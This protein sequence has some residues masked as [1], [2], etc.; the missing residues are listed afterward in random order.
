MTVRRTSSR[1]GAMLL[2]VI[3]SLGLLTGQAHAETVFDDSF[4]GNPADR[5]GGIPWGDGSNGFDIGRG[6][7]RTGANNGWLLAEN[8]GSALARG[9]NFP[10][11]EAQCAAQIYV[12]PSTDDT[13]MVLEVWGLDPNSSGVYEWR[14]RN[15]SEHRLNAGGY[16]AVGFGVT[17]STFGG[18]LELHYRVFLHGGGPGR[19]KMARLDDFFARCW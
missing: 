7:A 5:W 3:A 2:C 11:L 4:E 1:L 17:G 14:R 15:Y 6:L 18:T 13:F 8:G 9:I 10:R 19:L 16:Q 12:K